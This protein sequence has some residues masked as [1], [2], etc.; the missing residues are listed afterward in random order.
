MGE[1][2]SYEDLKNSGASFEDDDTPMSYDDL[3]RAGATFHDKP[4]SSA[5]GAFV[6]GAAE[7]AAPAIGGLGA[8]IAAGGAIGTAFAPGIGTG[9]GAAV[10]GLA[11]GM[12]AGYLISKGQDWVLDKLGLRNDP[13]SA[14][15][16]QQRAADEEAHP[17]VRFAGEMAP[18][19]A[20]LR[21]GGSLLQRGV[22]AA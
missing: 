21:P 14:F 10:G 15:S 22:G 8:G 19:A 17:Y 1:G 12:G 20:L 4:E 13:D 3:Y 7:G 16:N 11:A 18:A 2:L 6:R 5:G 9:I